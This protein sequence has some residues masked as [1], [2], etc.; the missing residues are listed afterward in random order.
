MTPQHDAAQQQP[1]RRIRLR[2]LEH[3][4]HLIYVHV[5]RSVLDGWALNVN[6]VGNGG[7]ATATT[8]EVAAPRDARYDSEEEAAAAGERMAKDYVDKLAD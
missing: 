2:T 3:K 6:V 8:Y 4:N 1:A 5:H 7:R